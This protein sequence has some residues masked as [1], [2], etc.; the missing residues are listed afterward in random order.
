M[1]DKRLNTLRLSV[2]FSAFGPLV[3]AVALSMNTSTTQFAD[4]LRRTVELSVL[5]IALWIYLKLKKTTLNKQKKHTLQAFM[6]R[7]SGYVLLISSMMLF[8]LFG[9]ALWNPAIP[10]GNVII[11]L[12]VAFL[13]VFFNGYFWF[14]YSRFNDVHN[15]VVMESQGKIYQAKTFVDINVVIAL[16]SVLVFPSLWISYWIDLVGTFI[17]AIYLVIRGISFIKKSSKGSFDYDA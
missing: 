12:V 13:G 17:I 3:L 16:A 1:S 8:F 7:I 6:Y 15:H 2:I 5:I 11:G 10:E 14:R 9:F 4:F